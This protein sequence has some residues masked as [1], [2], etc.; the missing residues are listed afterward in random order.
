MFFI[1]WWSFC[2]CALRVFCCHLSLTICVCGCFWRAFVNCRL[3]MMSDDGILVGTFVKWPSAI[4][5]FSCCT[6]INYDVGNDA[7]KCKVVTWCLTIWMK[8]D[9]VD[10]SMLLMSSSF[11]W[12]SCHEMHLCVL[13][14]WMNWWFGMFS[15]LS[16]NGLYVNFNIWFY[17]GGRQYKE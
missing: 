3:L 1:C 4:I 14:N 17:L 9:G 15:I 10:C 12:T 8:V 7:T 2:G 5:K 16:S 13:R 6:T 11:C